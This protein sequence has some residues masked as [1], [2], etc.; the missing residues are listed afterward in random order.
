MR[1]GGWF[2]RRAIPGADAFDGTGPYP[3]FA[4]QDWSALASDLEALANGLVSV[5]AAP[6]P[7]GAYTLSDLRH[8]F[9]DLVVH[10]KDHYVAD[11]SRPRNEIV[12]QHRRRDA[13]RAL[14]TLEIE[15]SSEPIRYLDEFMNLFDAAVQKFRMNGIRAFSRS[16]IAKQFAVPGC[17]ISLARYGGEVVAAE[18]FFVQGDTAY[19]HIAALSDAGRKLGASLALHYADIDYY[20]GKARWLDWGGDAGIAGRQGPLG[21]FKR[22]FSTETR[23]AYFCGRIFDR[24]RYD[25]L[26]RARG[27][28]VERESYFPAYRKGEF[29]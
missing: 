14:G 29:A 24:E 4:C 5:A 6:D 13:E 26:A 10:F 28:A 1:S 20:A 12:S 8:T 9:P 17:Y 7:L 2:L 19:A 15:F 22:G 16:S 3:Y 25:L 21:H 18:T 11:L 27:I 23:P